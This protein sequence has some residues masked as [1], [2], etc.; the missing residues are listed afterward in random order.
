MKLT[1]ADLSREST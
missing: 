1:G